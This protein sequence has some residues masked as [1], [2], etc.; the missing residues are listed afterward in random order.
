MHV[1]TVLTKKKTASKKNDP[2][3]PLSQSSHIQLW[4]NE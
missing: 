1:R 2:Q 3:Q 4:L